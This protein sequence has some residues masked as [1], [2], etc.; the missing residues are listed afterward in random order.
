MSCTTKMSIQYAGHWNLLVRHQWPQMEEGRQFYNLY[1]A[2]VDDPNGRPSTC[3]ATTCPSWLAHLL[4]SMGDTGSNVAWP[5]VVDR[6]GAVAPKFGQL[7]SRVEF[8]AH[9][10]CVREAALHTT[11]QGALAVCELV[12]VLCERRG[13][14]EDVPDAEFAAARS[15]ARRVELTTRGQPRLDGRRANG[16][17]AASAAMAAGLAAEPRELRRAV[18]LA[19]Y[20]ARSAAA[21]ASGGWSAEKAADRLT[22]TILDLIEADLLDQDAA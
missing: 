8:Q 14:G 16:G 11:N 10:A 21:R 6:V 17:I 15:Q 7:R 20:A 3:P 13:T 2:M 9:A 12:A 22:A 1:T 5:G 18:V 19:A 4:P